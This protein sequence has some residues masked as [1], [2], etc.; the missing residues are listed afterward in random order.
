[1]HSNAARISA[2]CLNLRDWPNQKFDGNAMNHL[3]GCQDNVFLDELFH[4]VK[5][6]AGPN[7]VMMREE[8]Y[9]F[10]EDRLTELLQLQL[11]AI[12]ALGAL[13]TEQQ[14]NTAIRI[15]SIFAAKQACKEQYG[16]KSAVCME[17]LKKFTSDQVL[18]HLESVFQQHVDD[19]E[20]QL[21]AVMEAMREEYHASPFAIKAALVHE[22]HQIGVVTTVSESSI[23]MTALQNNLA[24]QLRM[25]FMVNPDRANRAIETAANNVVIIAV[26]AEVATYHAR[27]AALP[28]GQFAPNIPPLVLPHNL[29]GYDVSVGIFNA[30]VAQ[31]IA[32]SNDL[33]VPED[34]APCYT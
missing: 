21:H 17:W 5:I 3:T 25:L 10:M 15:T 16:V 32:V 2:T 27:N 20:V 14:L 4:Q 1:M 33:R 11:N 30:L 29:P 12:I 18:T 22:Q 7:G 23:M 13:A 31:H 28:A 9:K 34:V 8:K 6:A 19:P 24:R 26:N